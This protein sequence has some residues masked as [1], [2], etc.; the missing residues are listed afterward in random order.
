MNFSDSQGVFEVEARSLSFFKRSFLQ[1]APIS[2]DATFCWR[3][4]PLAKVL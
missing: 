4:R 1:L 2:P 3:L